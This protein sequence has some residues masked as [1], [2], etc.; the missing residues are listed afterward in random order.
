MIETEIAQRG[1]A[2]G[3]VFE[4][5]VDQRRIDADSETWAIRFDAY[6]AVIYAS[7]TVQYRFHHP[8]RISLSVEG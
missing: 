3:E 4:S 7:G 5:I 2:G 1:M 8:L 6:F